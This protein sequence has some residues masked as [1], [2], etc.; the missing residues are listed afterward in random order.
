MIQCLSK[1]ILFPRTPFSWKVLKKRNY[2]WYNAA[3]IAPW[4][5]WTSPKGG[6]CK[7]RLWG[8]CQFSPNTLPGGRGGN[9]WGHMEAM[10][11]PEK[12]LTPLNQKDPASTRL[13]QEAEECLAKLHPLRGIAVCHKSQYETLPS[14]S[15]A[16]KWSLYCWISRGLL[17][18]SEVLRSLE[19][20]GLGRWQSR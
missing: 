12:S 15:K 3:I 6:W 1:G 4:P 18:R 17:L 10:K 20:W 14:P 8:P 7:R 11:R 19:E 2:A 16:P 5:I 9:P 13:S